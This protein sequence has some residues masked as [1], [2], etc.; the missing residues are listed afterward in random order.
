MNAHQKTDS[1]HDQLVSDGFVGGF[2]LAEWVLA[3]RFWIEGRDAESTI[4]ISVLN[5][6]R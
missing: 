1:K 3:K 5:H 6:S 2:T 4:V